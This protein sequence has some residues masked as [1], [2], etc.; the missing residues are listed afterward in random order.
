MVKKGDTLIEVTLAIGIFSMVAIAIA[1]V[2]SGS[3]SG[4]QTALETTLT[5]EEIDTQAD[6]LRY[7]HTAYTVNKNDTESNHFASLWHKITDNAI[8]LDSVSGDS[9]AVLEYAPSSCADLYNEDYVQKYAF[10]LNPRA[11]GL[12]TNEGEVDMD[13]VYIPYSS[14]LL[15]PTNLYPRLVFGSTA[16]DEESLLAGATSSQLFRAEGIYAIAVRDDGTTTIVD[17]NG[18]EQSSTSAFYDFYIRSCWY[19]SNANEPSAIST[20]MRLYDPDAVNATQ[21][22]WVRVNFN[23]NYAGGPTFASMYGRKVTVPNVTRNKY[24][25]AGWCDGSVSKNAGGDDVCSGRIYAANSSV[26]GT[27]VGQTDVHNLTAVWERNKYTITYSLT[28]GSGTIGQ[29][30]CYE[31][32]SSN[33]VVTSTKPTRTDHL[34]NNWCLNYPTASATVCSGTSYA[35]GA[36]IP[37]TRFPANRKLTLYAN[38]NIYAKHTISYSTSGSAVAQTVCYKTSASGSCT[39]SS[40]RPTRAGY[41]FNRWCRT[42]NLGNPTTCSGTSYN[43]GATIDYGS[44]PASSHAITLY[45]VWDRRYIQ[46][47]SVATCRSE[48]S[49]AAQTLFDR[50]D[51]TAYTVRYAN[52]QCWMTS[53]LHVG[54]GSGTVTA[55]NSNFSSPASWNLQATTDTDSY[56]QARSSLY[57]NAGYYNFCAVSAGTGNGCTKS[58]QYTGNS[59]IC[60]ANWRL[61]NGSE[62]AGVRTNTAIFPSSLTSGQWWTSTDEIFN[63]DV[64]RLMCALCARNGN[65]YFSTTFDATACGQTYQNQKWGFRRSYTFKARCVHR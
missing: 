1:A 27:A 48:A 29:T 23:S 32:V 2:L 12:L 43:P 19:G 41:T 11:L 40:T 35:S 50:R 13:F 17:E 42:N 18:N 9:S 37:L 5:R 25:F 14:G 26:I 6:A 60:P 4:A 65:F 39:I 24:T 58:T 52:N 47:Y 64:G 61:P 63:D 55:A 16:T 15:Q 49:S 10:V 38:W 54:Y 22:G 59:D 31:D 62:M 3:T 46:D 33:C 7:V 21:V 51:N 34:F 28:G 36:S 8:D 20:L 30:I 57:G 53:D 56:T 45:A 44:F